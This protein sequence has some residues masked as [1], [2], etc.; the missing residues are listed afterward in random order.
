VAYRQRGGDISRGGPRVAA[1]A[2]PPLDRHCHRRA[3]EDIDRPDRPISS[4]LQCHVHDGVRHDGAGDSGCS[5]AAPAPPPH[6]RDVG[7]GGR[8]L[9]RKLSIRGQRCRGAVLGSRHIDRHRA[10]RLPPRVPAALSRRAGALL[11]RSPD[12]RRVLWNSRGC[13]AANLGGFCR[14][15]RKDGAVECADGDR[16][17]THLMGNPS[18]AKPSARSLYCGECTLGCRSACAMSGHTKRQLRALP[19]GSGRERR[20]NC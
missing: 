15:Q 2:R 14:R 20:R 7:A 9:C 17:G 16:R 13:L 6:R 18:A 3:L 1:P 8:P 4:Y 11:D 12:F 10:C 5:A 19:G